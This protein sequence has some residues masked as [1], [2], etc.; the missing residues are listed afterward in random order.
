[1]TSLK[2]FYRRGVPAA[3][4]LG[5]IVGAPDLAQ[6]QPPGGFGRAPYIPPRTS[7]ALSNPNL[8]PAPYAQPR[9]PVL[10]N[11]NLPPFPAY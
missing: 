11:P 9:V 3:L 7:G 5:L 8:P 2:L 6:A 4:L 1:M 10:S